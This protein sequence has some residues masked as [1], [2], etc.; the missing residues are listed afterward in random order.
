MKGQKETEK[1]RFCGR[2]EG[3]LREE[4]SGNGHGLGFGPIMT[5]P[6]EITNI[7]MVQ[8]HNCRRQKQLKN[9]RSDGKGGTRNGK[10]VYVEEVF[11]GVAGGEAEEEDADSSD[12]E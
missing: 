4:N 12:L 8:H 2:R 1:G 10:H 6:C 7:S 11:L 9:P 5:L 3:F